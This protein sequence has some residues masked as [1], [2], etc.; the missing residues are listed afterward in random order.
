MD[1]IL[2]RASRRIADGTQYGLDWPFFYIVEVN[3]SMPGAVLSKVTWDDVEALVPEAELH[4]LVVELRSQSMGLGSYRSRFD[5]L[6]ESE[7][8]CRE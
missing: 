2:G 6:A 4:D 5:H 7:P 3:F 1:W 8:A